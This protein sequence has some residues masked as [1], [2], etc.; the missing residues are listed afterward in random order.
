MTKMRS[1]IC[2]CQIVGLLLL[3]ALTASAEDRVV[4]GNDNNAK[5]CFVSIAGDEKLVY[6]YGSEWAIPHVH[7]LR[8]PSGKSL[9]LQR[10]E[11]PQ[12]FP[13]HRALW[14][15]DHVQL[16]GHKAVDYY[17]CWK[18]QKNRN[19]RAEGYHHFIRNVRV[20][21]KAMTPQNALIEADLQWIVDGQT[22]V[23]DEHREM[24]FV[25]LGEGEYFV[26]YSW[27][28]TAAHDDVKFV[29]DRVHYAWP[30][31]RLHPQFSGEQG[32]TITNDRGETGQKSTDGAL[33]KW[34]DYSNTVDGV[35]EGLAVFIYPDGQQHKW[36]TR[37][38]GTFGPRRS[39]AFSG[40]KFTLQKGA[41]LSGRVGI[42]V[43]R[44]D[45]TTGKVAE[46]YQQY[47]KDQL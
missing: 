4:V 9:L 20:D 34:I 17:H 14:V 33:A 28:L 42:L 43:H 27:K 3:A 25:A 12:K 47:I 35:T 16:A 8:S 44:G 2:L 26:D 45:V 10:A 19:D 11:P 23:L 13:H 21:Y 7:P 22:S 38:Y 41:S 39:A 31:V 18:N 6:Q 1:I 40:T 46:R 30:Y 15:A 24:K 5:K 32:G 29:S 36:L 37:E